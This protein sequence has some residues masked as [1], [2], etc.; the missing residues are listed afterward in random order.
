MKAILLTYLPLA[1]VIASCLG[2]LYMNYR[3]SRTRKQRGKDAD[4]FEQ[5][6]ESQIKYGRLIHLFEMLSKF[7]LTS[8][9]TNQLQD[10]MASLGVYTVVE[11]RVETARLLLTSYMILI[12]SV[13]LVYFVTDDLIFRVGAILVALVFR[14]DF[15]N[16][17]L[18]KER[19]AVWE[20][21][22]RSMASLKNEYE[23][24]YSVQKSFNKTIVEEK[25]KLIFA[26]VVKLFKSKQ[27]AADLAY[28]NQNNPN[29]IL[30]RFADLCFNSF[31]HG[32]SVS[33]ITKIDT[34]TSNLDIIMKDL[35]IDIDL[36]KKEKKR[37]Y[38]AE[39]LPLVALGIA[40]FAPGF[41]TSR[42]PGMH[43]FY[44]GAIGYIAIIVSVLVIAVGYYISSTLNDND[45]PIDDRFDFEIKLFLKPKFKTFWENR[46]PKF[47]LPNEDLINDSLSYLSQAQLK[48]RRVYSSLILGIITLI[49]TIVYVVVMQSTSVVDL[50]QLPKETMEVI[51]DKYDSPDD[52]AKKFV[53]DTEI[54]NKQDMVKALSSEGL[55]ANETTL[56]L[57]SDILLK[58]RESYLNARYSPLYLFIVFV[59]MVVGFYIPTILLNRRRKLVEVEVQYEILVLY[60]VVVQMMYTPLKLRDYLKRFVYISKLYP[61]THLD[62]YVHQFN[63]PIFIKESAVKMS[64]PQYYD[65]MEK[66]YTLRSDKISEEVFREIESK[67][68]YL[69]KQVT[70]M[71]E[72]ALRTNYSFLKIIVGAVLLTVITLEVIIPLAQFGLTSINQYGKLM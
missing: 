51:Q 47:N 59:A 36:A 23:R 7:P 31:Y 45:R 28:F 48:F 58:N 32:V 19:L 30:Q 37:F 2:F 44:N 20:D 34:F 27:P 9:G 13:V 4:Y 38:I 67:R 8:K 26:S 42:Y 22:Y 14:R 72:E 16:K 63:N 21:T 12:T 3:N 71:R 35:Q 43:Y 50:A 61:K 5:E 25:A 41:L 66:L 39:K 49:L 15:I 11:Q 1:L 10:L 54:T 68:E 62:C 64:N 33:P 40:A 69:F 70:E 60:A 56:D 52:F 17:K 57:V 29:Q 65:F 46:V 18:R 53:L 55:N 6:E 24:L